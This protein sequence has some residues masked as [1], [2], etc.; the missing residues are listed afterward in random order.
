MPGFSPEEVE[1]TVDTQGV[2]TLKGEHKSA[3]QQERTEYML[4]ELTWNSFR[5][6]VSLP[7]EVKPDE[8]SAEFK[9]GIL[10]VDIP[11]VKTAPSARV[12]VPVSAKS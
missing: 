1:I 12:K 4:R 6:D 10:T 7:G 2:L 3:Q 9:D 5:R 11:R 8:A